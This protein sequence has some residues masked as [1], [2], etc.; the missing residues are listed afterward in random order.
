MRFQRK[1]MLRCCKKSDL[2]ALAS[3]LAVVSE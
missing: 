1:D 3:E 2:A